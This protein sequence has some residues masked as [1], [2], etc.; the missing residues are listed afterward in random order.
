VPASGPVANWIRRVL[1]QSRVVEPRECSHRQGALDLGAVRM[2]R[3]A[4][5]TRRSR[6][7]RQGR[8]RISH[9]MSVT[10]VSIRATATATTKMNCSSCVPKP[11]ETFHWTGRRRG[12]SMAP[13]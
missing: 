12:Q 1:E 5:R 13:G 2:A 9:G 10:T 4:A 3:W 6:F 8:Y 7:H 11:R